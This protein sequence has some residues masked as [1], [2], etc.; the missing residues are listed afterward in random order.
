NTSVQEID[1]RQNNNKTNHMI[2]FISESSGSSLHRFTNTRPL[3]TNENP[4]QIN[5]QVKKEQVPTTENREPSPVKQWSRLLL[6]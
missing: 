4:V 5:L 2:E 3:M 1:N 6:S